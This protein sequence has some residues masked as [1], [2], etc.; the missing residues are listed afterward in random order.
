MRC[1]LEIES[2]EAG[3]ARND[4][5][6]FEYIVPLEKVK[7]VRNLAVVR[8]A[9]AADSAVK[10][11][12]MSGP[13]EFKSHYRLQHGITAAC[14]LANRQRVVF[15]RYSEADRGHWHRFLNHE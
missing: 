5:C 14:R 12:R 8:I 13:E 1:L 15:G 9:T 4:E 3:M 7:W 2:I 11:L 10:H 6:L